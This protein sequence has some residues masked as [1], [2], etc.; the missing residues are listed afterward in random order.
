M[1]CSGD[2]AP[3][4][5]STSCPPSFETV[6]YP[7]GTFVEA[8]DGRGRWRRD[9]R[10]LKIEV[11]QHPSVEFQSL[12]PELMSLDEDRVLPFINE[13]TLEAER[14]GLKKLFHRCV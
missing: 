5:W 6:L 11:L 9:G 4:L 12:Y 2:G 10:T 3:Q 7:N 8:G 1:A 13:Q 14:G